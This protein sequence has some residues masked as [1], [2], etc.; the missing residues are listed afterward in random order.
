MLMLC[1]VSVLLLMVTF[2]VLAAPLLR[3]VV[4]VD[5]KMIPAIRAVFFF[6]MLLA[7]PAEMVALVA[8]LLALAPLKLFLVVL[9]VLFV[10]SKVLA[11]PQLASTGLCPIPGALR[12]QL[13]LLRRPALRQFR[14]SAAWARECL[15]M[16]LLVAAFQPL[17]LQQPLRQCVVQPLSSYMRLSLQ[18]DALL[19]P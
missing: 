19:R 11:A 17:V 4:Q 10:V 14:R 5:L 7:V 1:V 6:W 16:V 8:L 9:L 12:H 15:L 13:L 3:A 18:H 2:L